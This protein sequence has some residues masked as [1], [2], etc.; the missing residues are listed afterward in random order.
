MKWKV[1]TDSKIHQKK[2][3]E[4]THTRHLSFRENEQR[5]TQEKEAAKDCH[6]PHFQQ[7]WENERETAGKGKVWGI[8]YQS[9]FIVLSMQRDIFV[10]GFFGKR[11]ERYSV[12]GKQSSWKWAGPRSLLETIV[13][14]ATALGLGWLAVTTS[15]RDWIRF[16]WPLWVNSTVN[17]LLQ[18]VRE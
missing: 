9:Q 10:D 18:L 15:H 16:S 7:E 1:S 13:G 6:L 3:K 11:T 4:K 17:Y 5:E 2:R 12:C 8:N 14:P